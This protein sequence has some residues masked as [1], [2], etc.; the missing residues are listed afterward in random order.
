MKN[1]KAAAWMV[2]LLGI[3]ASSVH[4]QEAATISGKVFE[5]GTKRP[6]AG[7]AITVSEAPDI[8]ATSADDGAFTLRLP[9]AGRYT[10]SASASGY[11]KAE[12]QAIEV[13]EGAAR[14]EITFYLLPSATLQE[15][16]VTGE[17]TPDRVSKTVITG[18]EARHVPGTMG[19][20]LR[21]V[22]SL[23]GVAMV[24]DGSGQVAVRGSSPADNAY[25][26]DSLPIGY[27]FH[28]DGSSVFNPDLVSDFNLYSAA[29]PP[30]YAD[31]TGAV[32]DTAL[33]DPRTDRVGGKVSVSLLGANALVEGPVS[34]NQSF[35]LAGRRSYFDLFAAKAT[36]NGITYQFPDYNDY[37]GKYLWRI[38]ENNR[39]SLYMN[40]AHDATHMTVAAGSDMALS[41]P[42]LAGDT[43]WN[44][45]YAMQALM[46]DSVLS[47][48]TYNKLSVGRTTTLQDS[49][50]GTAASLKVNLRTTFAREQLNFVADKHDIQLNGNYAS[51]TVGLDL[52]ALNGF[53]T[54]FNPNCDLTTAPRV[55]LNQ[56]IPFR[57]WDVSARDRWAVTQQTTLIGGVRNSHDQYLRQTYTEPR[58]GMEYA[59][60]PSTLL[61]AGWGRH[62]EMPQGQEI[63]PNFGNPT[64][65]HVRAEHYVAGITRTLDDGWSWKN[66]VYY[67][68]LWDLVVNDPTLNYVNGGSGKAYGFETLIKKTHTDRLSGWLS[69]SLAKSERHNDITGENFVFAYDQPVNATWVNSY[70]LGGGWTLGSKWSYHTGSPYTPVIGT[71][72][73]YPDGRVRPVYGPINSARFPAYHRLDLRVDRTYVYNTWK[74]TTFFEIINA[75]NSKNVA[76]YIYGPNYNKKDPVYGLPFLP[77]F[78]IEAEF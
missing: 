30:Y 4:A 23:P 32:L 6:L 44:V 36:R 48:T 42:V 46:L 67:K 41:Q 53:C 29:F 22:Q 51:T 31:V 5:K 49:N 73:T 43:N 28:F 58:L 40:G 54:Q 26:V 8:K 15:V 39:L 21:A 57:E 71:N 59:W 56:S 61:S 2:F 60:S 76:G 47:P 75:Y 70:K 9:K 62:N 11:D 65:V 13:K 16:V 17:R 66:E 63:V 20:P 50:L 74:L 72:G 34:E 7:A 52:N 19:D 37:Q 3:V 38:N 12:F 25:Y 35:Y 14:A 18:D 33:R 27:L 1:Y 45:S 77:T 10:F 78:G 64:L 68:K 24:S 55:M 69:L